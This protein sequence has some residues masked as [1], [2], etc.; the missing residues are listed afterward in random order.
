MDNYDLFIHHRGTEG[1]ERILFLPDRETT[2]G[3]TGKPPEGWESKRSEEKRRQPSGHFL[4]KDRL[5]VDSGFLSKR[6]FAEGGG[7]F[8]WPSSPGQ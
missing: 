1:T 7:T 6:A 3:Q 4:C 2:I 5:E 8:H